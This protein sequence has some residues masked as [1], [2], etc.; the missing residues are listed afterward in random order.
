VPRNDSA[1]QKTEEPTPRRIREARK[2]GQV[3]K[4]SDLNGAL[5]LLAALILF[6]AFKD[7]MLVNL[8]KWLVG[9]LNTSLQYQ[10]GSGDIFEDILYVIKSS[11]VFFLSF[12]GPIFALL[13]L[14]ALLANLTQVGFLF[15]PEV[16]T[17]K[18]ERLNPLNGLK[19]I[20]SRRSLVEFGKMLVKVFVV[21]GVVYWLVKSKLPNLMLVYNETPAGALQKVTDFMLLI[22]GAGSLTYLVLAVL[23][24]FYQY[25]EYKKELRMTK[26]ELK[27]E[28]KQ[29]EGDPMIKAMQRERRRQIALNRI[30]YEVPRATVVVTNPVHVA[31]ALRYDE[32]EMNAPRV[33]AKG[34]NLMAE[35]IKRIAVEN[36]VPIVEKPDLARFLFS[37]VEVGEEI[38]VEIYQ[39]VAEI[40]AMIY[41]LRG[42]GRAAGGL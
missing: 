24:Y 10:T 27:D 32:D 4:S 21:G 22:I 30:K 38:P 16:I 35:R 26:Q 14:V 5:I 11:L 28:L 6:Y 40:L 39:A 2:K 9:Y 15:A 31:V 7:S 36:D 17:P 3:A 37:R 25:Y 19:R 42:Y 1:Q 34:A 8:Q 18:A 13:V 41:R 12:A 20:F 29:T 33:T 23:D